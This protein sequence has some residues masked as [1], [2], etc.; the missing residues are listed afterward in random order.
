MQYVNSMQMST[1]K[2]HTHILASHNRLATHIHLLATHTPSGDVHTQTFWPHIHLLAM[3]THK[4]SGHTHTF[5]PCTGLSAAVPDMT[6]S[7]IHQ[8]THSTE[9]S[10]VVRPGPPAGL[11]DFGQ[12]RKQT[13]HKCPTLNANC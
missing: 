7:F 2:A 9:S 12:E 11:V 4:P 10:W 3:Y 13:G 5:W 1:S 8:L 6:A